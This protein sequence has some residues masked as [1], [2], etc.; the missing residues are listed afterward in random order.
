MFTTIGHGIANLLVTAGE[1]IKIAVQ[2][3]ILALAV[4]ATVVAVLMH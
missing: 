1:D 4:A 2:R 3:Y